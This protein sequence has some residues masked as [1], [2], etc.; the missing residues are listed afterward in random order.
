MAPPSFSKSKAHVVSPVPSSSQNVDHLAL[1]MAV[2]NSLEMGCL[3]LVFIIYVPP[4]CDGN[5]LIPYSDASPS[6][7]QSTLLRKQGSFVLFSLRGGMPSLS[8]KKRKAPDDTADGTEQHQN[9]ESSGASKNSNPDKNNADKD[10]ESPL[11]DSTVVIE[12]DDIPSDLHESG[13]HHARNSRANIFSVCS[14][15]TP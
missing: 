7:D 5:R 11:D 4:C 2:R 10:V 15:P 8:G 3:I 12:G 1:R 6:T 9:D 14:Q 13:H